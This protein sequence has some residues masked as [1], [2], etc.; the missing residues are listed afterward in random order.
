MILNPWNDFGPSSSKEERSVYEHRPW[1]WESM[2]MRNERSL[3]VR[4]RD[5]IECVDK[6]EWSL[7]KCSNSYIGPVEENA[8]ERTRENEREREKK[9]GKPM[10]ERTTQRRKRVMLTIEVTRTFCN[11][12]FA[13][14][15]RPRSSRENTDLC[16]ILCSRFLR[17][18]MLLLLLFFVLGLGQSSCLNSAGFDEYLGSTGKHLFHFVHVSIDSIGSIDRHVRSLG[19]GHRHSLHAFRSSGSNRSIWTILQSD[20]QVVDQATSHC[21]LGW[22][23]SQSW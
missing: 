22:F 8:F 5:V 2:S 4:R 12:S 13:D 21:R 11:L 3:S 7:C 23:D 19:L 10:W 6:S 14:G 9:W 17:S 1:R 18:R 15:C 20:Y 16:T